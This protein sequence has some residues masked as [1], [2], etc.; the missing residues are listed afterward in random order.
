MFDHSRDL[1]DDLERPQTLRIWHSMW[2]DRIDRKAAY[3]RQRQAEEE[4]RQHTRPPAPDWILELSRANGNPQA[5]HVGDCGMTGRQPRPVGQDEARR[6]L[7]VDGVPACPICRPD[8][9]LGI[10]D[11]ADPP[12]GHARRRGS[13]T[14][15]RRLTILPPGQL[16]PFARNRISHAHPST[17]LDLGTRSVRADLPR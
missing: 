4:R 9:A 8:S 16:A 7:T 15:A 1:P 6:L 5:V 3:L 17:T 11:L 10:V 12:H 2:L 14:R 13:N